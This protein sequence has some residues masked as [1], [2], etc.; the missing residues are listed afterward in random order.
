MTRFKDGGVDQPYHEWSA[1]N[2][3]EGGEAGET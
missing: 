2:E 1:L 3:T